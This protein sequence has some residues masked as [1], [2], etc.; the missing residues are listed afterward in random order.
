MELALSFMGDCMK[1]LS[2]NFSCGGHKTPTFNEWYHENCSEK[3]RFG[4][5]EYSEEQGREVY[6]ELVE[7][8]FFDK[9]GYNA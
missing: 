4:E 5:R 3:R 7:S 1:Q 9:G 8:G 2:F 6:N